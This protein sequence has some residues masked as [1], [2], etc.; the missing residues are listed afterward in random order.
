MNRIRQLIVYPRTTQNLNEMRF[1]KP[2][3]CISRKNVV[4]LHRLNENEEMKAQNQTNVEKPI[5]FWL[6]KGKA[7]G[8][9]KPTENESRDYRHE[10]KTRAKRGQNELFSEDNADKSL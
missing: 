4:P 2:K 1:A 5:D 8:E 3:I 6:R 10:G 7:G 9:P